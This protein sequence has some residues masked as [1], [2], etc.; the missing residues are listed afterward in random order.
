MRRIISNLCW[1]ISPTRKF[2][3]QWKA[4][5]D[6]TYRGKALRLWSRWL[7]CAEAIA[8]VALILLLNRGPSNAWS[9]C[10]VALV[11][12]AYSRIVEIAYAF[13]RDPLSQSK[14][15]D[16]TVKDRVVM[17]MRSYFGLA[18]NFAVLY[19]FLPIAGLFTRPSP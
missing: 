16:L 9:I 15:S 2:I 18:F 13:Y 6:R 17:T 14:E 7:F 10:G 11:V 4:R 5:G 19:Y 3:D 1:L 12:Y 8:C